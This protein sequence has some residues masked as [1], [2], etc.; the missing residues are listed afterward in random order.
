[1]VFGKLSSTRKINLLNYQY[2]LGVS[3]ILLRDCIK[4]MG[5]YIYRK[6][7]FYRDVNFLLSHAMKLLGLIRTITFSFLTIDCL[8]MLQYILFRSDLNF[9][10]LLMVGTRLRLLAP[11]NQR[12][13]KENWQAF[14]ITDFLVYPV[15]L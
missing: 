9:S 15:L 14:A 2:L 7:H 6:L 1:M 13:Y 4:D 5:I 11:T 8:L 12:V 10:I 3:I